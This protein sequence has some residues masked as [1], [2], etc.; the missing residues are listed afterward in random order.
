MLKSVVFTNP[1]LDRSVTEL[2]NS[3]YIFSRLRPF[4]QIV[5][6]RDNDYLKRADGW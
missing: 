5:W 6:N 1:I 3:F 2:Y 4:T